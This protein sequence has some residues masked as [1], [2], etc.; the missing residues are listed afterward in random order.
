MTSARV[1]LQEALVATWLFDEHSF[2]MKNCSLF[3]H[4]LILSFFFICRRN[5][6]NQQPVLKQH[7]LMQQQESKPELPRLLPPL[8]SLVKFLKLPQS[9]LRPVLFLGNA[10]GQPVKKKKKKARERCSERHWHCCFHVQRSRCCTWRQWKI[11]Q[12]QPNN[13]CTCRIR[14]EKV[15]TG[16]TRFVWW[17]KERKIQQQVWVCSRS[18]EGHFSLWQRQKEFPHHCVWAFLFNW[19]WWILALWRTP[20]ELQCIRLKHFE[21][22]C[23]CERF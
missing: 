9:A 6:R 15:Q 4:S 7:P 14:K 19:H 23:L 22:W 20:S 21:L 8:P 10:S 18:Q 2:E 3:A 5:K 13:S 12:C 17:Q 11:K 16:C 1:A